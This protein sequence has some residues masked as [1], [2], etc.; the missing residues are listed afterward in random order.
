MICWYCGTEEAAVFAREHQF[1]LTQGGF[2]PE[3]LR[4]LAWK[5]PER[6]RYYE[7][8]Y[9]RD[10]ELPPDEPAEGTTGGLC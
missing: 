2:G 8:R 3:L 4:N 10:R 1:P 7:S 9:G 5:T 6:W